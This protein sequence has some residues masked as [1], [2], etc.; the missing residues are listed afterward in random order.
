MDTVGVE[1]DKQ[2][3]F[4]GFFFA[5]IKLYSF[6]FFVTLLVAGLNT[7]S[8]SQD[9]NDEHH[10]SP[11]E[12][13]MEEMKDHM[14]SV[15]KSIPDV[16]L[17]PQCLE[18]V[19]AMQQLAIDALPYCPEY[20]GEAGIEQEKYKI[21]FKRRLLVVADTLLELELAL[22]SQNIEAAQEFYQR[23]KY[24]KKESHDVYDPEDE[25]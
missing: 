11:L 20:S 25:E 18:D 10:D 14:R 12:E 2:R 23:L 13:I 4:G 22:H 17:H 3:S 16:K 15:R 9:P 7:T 5:M 8:F 6:A 21:N 19:Q 24:A 1:L